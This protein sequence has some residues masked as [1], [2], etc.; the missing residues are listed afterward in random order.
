VAV[1][2]KNARIAWAILAHGRHFESLHQ[3]R[4]GEHGLPTGVRQ[5]A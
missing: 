3:P 4:K 2:N 5:P 1:A